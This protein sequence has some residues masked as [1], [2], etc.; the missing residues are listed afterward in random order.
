MPVDYAPIVKD[1]AVLFFGD[2]HNNGPIRRHIANYARKLK[3]SGIT[4]LALEIPKTSATVEKLMSALSARQSGHAVD[5]SWVNKEA[6]F[7][8]KEEAKNYDLLVRAFISE[9]ITVVP[10]DIVQDDRPTPEQRESGITENIKEV[11]RAGQGNK[12]AVLL[13]DFHTSK[14]YQKPQVGLSANGRLMSEGI[15]TASV[16]FL[17]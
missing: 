15:P 13:G 17:T 14:K 10:I 4:H 5:L 11:L 8:P 3:E 7:T 12:I 2:N 6:P 16:M 9:G 1:A